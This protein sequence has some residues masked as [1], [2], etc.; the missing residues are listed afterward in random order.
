MEIF[1]TLNQ[2]YLCF[3][4]EIIRAQ[5]SNIKLIIVIEGTLSQIIKGN[6]YST[7]KGI[8][9]FK[10]LLTLKW[11]YGIDFHCFK[12]KEEMV[13]YIIYTFITLGKERLRKNKLDR[14]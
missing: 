1:Q 6:R 7:I 4:R 14:T 12:T 5:E 11:R 3:K 9:V 2:D 10:K 13:T 8:S